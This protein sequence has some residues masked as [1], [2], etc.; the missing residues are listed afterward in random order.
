ML[1]EFGRK[2]WLDK[3]RSQ[4]DKVRQVLDKVR[5]DGVLSTLEAVRAKLDQPLAL[6]YANAGGSCSRWVRTCAG[7]ARAIGSSPT[8]GTPS[9]SA[10]R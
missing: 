7:S 10:C 3:A 2:H 9:A 5:T 1:V 8:G 4:P 6:G